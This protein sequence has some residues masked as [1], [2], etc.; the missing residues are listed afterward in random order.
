MKARLYRWRGVVMACGAFL[1][2]W[3]GSGDPWPFWMLPLSF[4]MGLRLWARCYIGAHSRGERLDVPQLSQGGPYDILRHPLYLSNVAM[5]M[6][7]L[8]WWRGLH[9]SS[10]LL[11][12]LVVIF[13]RALAQGEDRHLEAVLGESWRLWKARVPGVWWP[14][15]LF[16]CAVQPVQQTWWQAFYGDLWTWF[17]LG[18]VFLLLGSLRYFHVA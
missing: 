17:W 14:V 18:F 16:P 13:Y 7:I 11:A 6:G 10:V 12:S 9:W 8:L 2:L 5:A 4:G 3:L 15:R 1:A